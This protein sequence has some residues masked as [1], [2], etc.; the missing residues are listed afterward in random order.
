[1]GLRLAWL[2]TGT[3]TPAA[4][5]RLVESAIANDTTRVVAADLLEVDLKPIAAEVKTG[6]NRLQKA[7]AMV[8]RDPEILGGQPVFAGT[9]V[10]V[11]DVADMLANGDPVET[12]YSAYPQ[13]TL[14]RIR[15]A[16]DYALAYPRRGRPPSKPARREMR[17]RTSRTVRLD[18]LPAAS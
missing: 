16:G 18:D 15:L 3:L 4:R 5:K 13:L 12:I 9:R 10:P 11:H 1:M 6:L 2:T 7:R 8:T 14:D 17:A